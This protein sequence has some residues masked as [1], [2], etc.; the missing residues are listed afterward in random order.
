[1]KDRIYNIRM[2][3]YVASFTKTHPRGRPV[4]HMHKDYVP[5]KYLYYDI[6][7]INELCIGY[8]NELCLRFQKKL[9]M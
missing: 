3:Y 1:M 9:G 7:Y 2:F 8:I 4:F 5:S 6:G